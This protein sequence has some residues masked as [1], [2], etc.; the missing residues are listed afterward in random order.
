MIPARLDFPCRTNADYTEE[1]SASAS[2]IPVDLT[3][4]SAVLTARLSVTDDVLFTLAT[5]TSDIEGLRF[6]E[7]ANGI[8]SIRVDRDTLSAAYDAVATYAQ[9]GDT[10]NIIHDV[11]FTAPNGDVEVWFEGVI[12]IKKGVG[13]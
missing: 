8:I 1:F 13:A 11:K 7:P 2:G 5:V 4:Y 6:V 10:V 3:G 9:L 12:A